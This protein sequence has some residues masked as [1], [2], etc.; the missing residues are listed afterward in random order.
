MFTH[1]SIEKFAVESG[2]HNSN[3]WL[4]CAYPKK[5]DDRFSEVKGF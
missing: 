4:S 2:M 3:P 5:A 1:N